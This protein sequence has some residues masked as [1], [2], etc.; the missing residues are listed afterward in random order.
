MPHPPQLLASFCVSTQRTPPPFAQ[1]MIPVPMQ[2]HMPP[3]HAEP[4]GHEVPHAPQLRESVI[5]STH[6]PPQLVIVPAHIDAHVPAT[7]T[8]VVPLHTVEQL[9]QCCALLVT[10]MHVEPHSA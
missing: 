9:P 1:F 7:H 4:T 10:S 2:R 5:V 6:V 3:E 8:G